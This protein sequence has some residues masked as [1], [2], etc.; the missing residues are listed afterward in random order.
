MIDALPLLL[1]PEGYQISRSVRLRSSASAY[2]NRTPASAGNRKTWTWSGWV[3]LGSLSTTLNLMYAYSADS[4]SGLC[5]LSFQ[6]NQLRIQGFSA[7]FLMVSTPV[8]RDPS[9][10]YHI[11]YK[12]DT[13]QATAA[14]RV[15]V[16]VNGVEITAWATNTPPPQNTDTAVNNNVAHNIGRNTR[17]SNDYLDGYLTEINLIDGQALDPSYFGET[18]AVT[19]VW[20][21]KKYTGTYGTNGFYLNFSDNSAATAAAIGKDYSGNGNNWT[22]NNISVT[23]GVT[24][25]SM[26]DVPTQWADGGNGRGN[27]AVLNPIA[28]DKNISGAGGTLSAANLQIAA[29]GSASDAIVPTGTIPCTGGKFYAELTC[30]AAGSGGSQTTYACVNGIGSGAAVYFAYEKGG[31]HYDPTNGWVAGWSSWTT[32]DV[33]GITIDQTVSPVSVS[34]YKNNTLQGTLTYTT[35]ADLTFAVRS[36]Y[37]SSFAV[38]FGQR[39]FAFSVPSGFKALNTLN[40]P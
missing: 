16:Y 37:A 25:D 19:G 26:L 6:S 36:A 14:N 34:F 15:R 22:P 9:A 2:L 17:N 10:W 13:T 29:G 32:N 1:G 11:V 5:Q 30:L 21:P 28:S 18:N 35:T 3:K 20:Q 7:S 8:Y 39:P 12:V 27:Y 33:I 38:N 23:A 31:Q 4:D 24:Y 40:L